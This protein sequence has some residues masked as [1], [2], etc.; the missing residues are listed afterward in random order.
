[1]LSVVSCKLSV[2]SDHKVLSQYL[3]MNQKWLYGEPWVHDVQLRQVSK[4]FEKL[5]I[6]IEGAHG[7][8][9]F[10]FLLLV[11]IAYYLLWWG[12]IESSV[13]SDVQEEEE[14]FTQSW[15]CVNRGIL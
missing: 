12:I 5:S 7:L 1:M 3:R 2:V 14:Y 8:F 15:R 11:Y 13:G 6:S 4:V 10:L 9:Y